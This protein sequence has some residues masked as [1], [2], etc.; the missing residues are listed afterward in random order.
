MRAGN[1]SK[2][3]EVPDVLDFPWLEE[4]DAEFEANQA[5]PPAAQKI[6]QF[7][8][9]LD[10]IAL[11]MQLVQ[12]LPILQQLSQQQTE[13]FAL[14]KAMQVQIARMQKSDSNRPGWLDAEEARKYLSMSKNTFDKYVYTGK[15]KVKRY[16]VGG[17]NFF[18]VKDLDLFMMTW[19]DK[20]LGFA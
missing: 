4:Q 17:K 3:V 14:M 8:Q 15:I 11:G 19:E 16:R 9:P 1:Q 20:T 2:S 13:I 12:V 18:C 10:S 6:V 5:P 7:N